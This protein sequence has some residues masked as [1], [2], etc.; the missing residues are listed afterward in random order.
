MVHLHRF[1]KNIVAA[2]YTFVPKAPK[3]QD[4]KRRNT[5]K[6]GRRGARGSQTKKLKERD[7]PEEV[8]EDKEVALLK[9][10]NG[11]TPEE[12]R[13][14]LLLPTEELMRELE[15]LAKQAAPLGSMEANLE[16]SFGANVVVARVPASVKMEERLEEEEVTSA[17]H[18]KKVKEEETMERTPQPVAELETL[19]TPSD[20]YVG[21]LLI[22]L[23][24]VS[25]LSPT[26]SKKGVEDDSTT[27]QGPDP[28]V[29]TKPSC[30]KGRSGTDLENS[31][32]S[33]IGKGHRGY[34]PLVG[35]R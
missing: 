15:E 31:N 18:I 23:V 32:T 34:D 11:A 14:Q 9:E 20:T 22:L 21:S 6:L 19:P 35:S 27:V 17:L 24:K 12:A 4:L 33:L 1:K 30:R 10:G 13:D 25:E 28:E 16:L 8:A 26:P 3:Q 5:R 7:E 2:Y 29:E